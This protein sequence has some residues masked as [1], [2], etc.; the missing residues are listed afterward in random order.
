MLQ[1]RCARHSTAQ[2]G[3]VHRRFGG[4]SA[5]FG[6]CPGTERLRF[7]WC[8]CGLAMEET[9]VGRRHAGLHTGAGSGEQAH[10]R[11]R[12][13][14]PVGEVHRRARLI[15]VAS[16]HQESGATEEYQGQRVSFEW[17]LAQEVLSIV[18]M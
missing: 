1:G 14:G 15:D 6:L 10:G 5:R 9:V 7:F 11:A 17:Q 16:K 12:T 2:L 8:Q 18:W 3:T 13:R 4:D